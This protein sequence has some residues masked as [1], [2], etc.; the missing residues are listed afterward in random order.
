[1][2]SLAPIILVLVDA[3]GPHCTGFIEGDLV[4]S[5]APIMMVSVDEDGPYYLVLSVGCWLLLPPY[6]NSFSG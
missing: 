4:A 5:S 6:E 2:A 3:E 1:M